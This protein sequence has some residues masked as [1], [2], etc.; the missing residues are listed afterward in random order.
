MIFV[1]RKKNQTPR[2]H[3]KI[4]IAGRHFVHFRIYIIIII[5]SIIIIIIVIIIIIIIMI[6]D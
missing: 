3:K 1:S 6:I 2:I 5:I 4:I